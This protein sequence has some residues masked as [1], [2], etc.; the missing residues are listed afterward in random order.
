MIRTPETQALRRDYVEASTQR[1]ELE[2]RIERLEDVVEDRRR[3]GMDSDLI[4][5][6]ERDLDEAEKNL[7]E[8]GR[9]SNEAWNEWADKSEYPGPWRR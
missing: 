4:A 6:A 1:R 7:A 8:V 3:R 2:G 5:S 9:R